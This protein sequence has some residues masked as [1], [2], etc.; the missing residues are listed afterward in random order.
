MKSKSYNEGERRSVIYLASHLQN[1]LE[2]NKKQLMVYG[3]Q[4]MSNKLNDFLVV[5]NF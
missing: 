3:V 1:L 5:V 2:P 4:H